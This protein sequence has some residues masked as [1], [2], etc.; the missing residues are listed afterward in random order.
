VCEAVCPAA[1]E[2]AVEYRNTV[3]IRPAHATVFFIN[4]SESRCE[5]G[6]NLKKAERI[7]GIIA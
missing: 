3:P 1:S 4:S 7:S 2:H 6:R 5:W